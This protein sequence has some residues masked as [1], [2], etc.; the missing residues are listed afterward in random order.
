MILKFFPISTFLF[1]KI[2]LFWFGIQRNKA[3]PLVVFMLIN[4]LLLFCL[5]IRHML[6]GSC[7]PPLSVL[8]NISC[9]C[10]CIYSHRSPCPTTSWLSKHNFL[11]S[12]STIWTLCV[13]LGLPNYIIIR[14]EMTYGM[15]ITQR[16]GQW[17]IWDKTTS[18]FLHQ[19]A[20]NWF[21]VLGNH[22]ET[23]NLKVLV[24]VSEPTHNILAHKLIR[25]FS[26]KTHC[27]F[28]G[29]TSQTTMPGFSNDQRKL[30]VF[31]TRGNPQSN[32]AV[33]G[34]LHQ[35]SG[36]RPFGQL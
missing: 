34:Q 31:R 21:C 30:N 6:L 5:L 28:R 27:I 23:W 25:Q 8:L 15:Q 35:V 11:S 26:I 2:V 3:L 1:A 14:R 10:K 29:A 16:F 22:L 32:F 9:H 33:W 13:P 17:F 4:L 36:S 12:P 24:S 20:G 18:L 7:F 19:R